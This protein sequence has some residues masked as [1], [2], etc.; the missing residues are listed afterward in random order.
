[1]KTKLK[2]ALLSGACLAMAASAQAQNYVNGDLLVGFTGGGTDFIYDLG[3]FS[4][5][6]VGQ[7]WN[8]GSGLGAKFGV[9]G[10][11]STGKHIYATS[12]DSTEN[13]FDPTALYNTASANIRTISGQPTALTIGTSRT[14]GPGDTTSWTY[15]TAQPP[16]T[17][18]NTF[19]NNFFDPNVNV[20]SPAYF[21]DNPNT[22]GVTSQNAWFTYDSA[23]GVLS[24][25]PEPTAGCLLG[26]GSLLIL[27]LRRQGKHAA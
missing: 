16:G 18:G 6:S 22:G 10:A 2:M 23:N 21:F 15:Q 26:G 25:V 14:P 17:P 5:L 1:M 20:G 7:T 11:Q 12:F 9:V 4:S 19:E 24:Y 3:Q 8:I 27:G 13:S